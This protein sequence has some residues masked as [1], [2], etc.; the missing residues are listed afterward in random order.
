[1]AEEQNQDQE[2]Q[3]VQEVQESKKEAAGLASKDPMVEVRSEKEW[4]RL[5]HTAGLVVVDI[6]CG[7]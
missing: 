6:Y 2:V 7:W 1:M 4:Q 5:I 3:E